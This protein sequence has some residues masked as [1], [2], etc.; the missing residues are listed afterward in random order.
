MAG[1]FF[2]ARDFR[3]YDDPDGNTTISSEYNGLNTGAEA[4]VFIALREAGNMVAGAGFQYEEADGFRSETRDSGGYFSDYA[5]ATYAFSGWLTGDF[6]IP[7]L[8]LPLSFAPGVRVNVYTD[9]LGPDPDYHH[10]HCNPELRIRFTHGSFTSNAGLALTHNTPSLRIRYYESPT[11][12]RNPGLLPEK[13]INFALGAGYTWNIP[14]QAGHTAIA[15]GAQ[16]FYSS[17]YD[18]ITYVSSSSSSIGQYDNLGH[19]FRRGADIS[20]SLEVDS[21][22]NHLGFQADL[23]SQILDARDRSTDLFLTASPVFNAKGTLRLCLFGAI[24]VRADG[25][26]VGKQYTTTDNVLFSPP[27]STVD[28]AVDLRIERLTLFC[29][30]ENVFDAQ[31]TNSIGYP[32]TP[33]AWMCG[34]RYSFRQT[35]K[36]S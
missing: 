2:F 20:I 5:D 13:G 24:T 9:Q 16:G 1:S 28:M 25:A 18:R 36:A 15:L 12:V 32:G 7:P 30:V 19:V 17:I 26:Y 10:A 4:R 11:T 8:N 35:R 14:K 27:Y 31:Y 34:A 22:F 21:L 33:R 3:G 6:K 29:E 23:S